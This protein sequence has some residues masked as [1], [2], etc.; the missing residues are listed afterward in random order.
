V[1]RHIALEPRGP[2]EYAV[3]EPDVTGLD[4]L[5]KLLDM[6]VLHMLL[7]TALV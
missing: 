7:E 1:N 4:V 3:A 5:F 6:D 2:Q